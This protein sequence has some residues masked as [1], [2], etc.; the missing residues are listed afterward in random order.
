MSTI[1]ETTISQ[2]III[3]NEAITTSYR[4]AATSR[5][6]RDGRVS[7]QWAS[8]PDDQKFL[9]LSALR[10]S[11]LARSQLSS[12]D[13][14]NPNEVRVIADENNDIF[15]DLQNGKKP[16]DLSHWSF[17]Q[18]SRLIGCPA[19]Y[20]RK[21]PNKIAAINL[22]HGL[23]AY[24][25]DEMQAYSYHNGSDV[26]RAMTGKNY[27]RI[28]DHAVVEQVMKIAGNGTGDTNWKVPGMIDWSTSAG[29]TVVYNPFVDITTETT[30]LYASD[31]D[32]YVFLVDDTHPIE[33]GKLPD[34]SPDLMFRGFI[35]WNSEVGS[36][37]FGITTMLLRGV[38]CNRNL[39]GCED[40]RDLRI[41]HTS[42]APDRFLAEAAP[43]LTQ[44]ANAPTAGIVSKVRNAKATIVAKTDE[45]RV[46]FLTERAKVTKSLADRALEAVLNEELHPATSV[47]DMVQ[48]LTAVARKIKH[49]DA[50]IELE[51]KAG[52]LM[53][54][55]AA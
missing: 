35:V 39:W 8:R 49:Q 1:I 22:Q 48:G 47:W 36:K 6:T 30:T 10:D 50:R 17:G 18:V 53:D 4:T 31:R 42:L 34:G 24:S 23:M 44:Y 14:I 19:D 12:C 46:D 5:G 11:V 51:T 16:V 41:R 27:G 52:K 28:H 55:I 29:G 38:C 25:G 33:V 9:S 3:E 13:I 15:F 26:L 21:L 43:M 37:S 40:V 2:P 32:V 54:R 7:A 20:I 45:E